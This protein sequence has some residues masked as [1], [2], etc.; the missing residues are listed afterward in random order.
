[1]ILLVAEQAMSP[2]TPLPDRLLAR[3]TT[4]LPKKRPLSSIEPA[5]LR[6]QLGGLF[7]VLLGDQRLPR[8]DELL[9]LEAEFLQNSSRFCRQALQFCVRQDLLF[10]PRDGD[11][12]A[13]LL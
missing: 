5:G 2:P 4:M 6:D 9:D 1:M 13:N 12:I 7:E 11:P 3:P 8:S 10:S